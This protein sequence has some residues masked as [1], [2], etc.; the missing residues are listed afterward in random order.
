VRA[1]G[2]EAIWKLREAWRNVTGEA[3]P[4]DW[5]SKRLADELF[6]R[7]DKQ[8]LGPAMEALEAARSHAKEGRPKDAAS[9][10]ELALRLAPEHPDRAELAGYLA[11]AGRDAASGLDPEARESLLVRASWAGGPELAAELAPALR[12]LHADVL[13]RQGVVDATLTGA[14]SS[15]KPREPS[16]PRRTGALAAIGACAIAFGAA[17]EWRRRKAV[18]TA[19]R[20]ATATPEHGP[21]DDAPSEE[22]PRGP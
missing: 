17:G 22:T 12:A 1:Y 15:E 13:A 11:A 18:R 2:R 20:E 21:R 10:A 7:L 3:A 14:A 16:A 5:Y 6:A 19:E 9:S 4:E 8:R